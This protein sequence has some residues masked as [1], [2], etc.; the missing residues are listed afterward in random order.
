M[1]YPILGTP[2]PTF[3][4]SSGDPLVSGT[5]TVTDPDTASAKAVYD[6][7]ADADSQSNGVTSAITLNS[8]GEPETELWGRDGE[9]YTLVVKDSA[10]STVQTITDVR[11]P[12]GTTSSIRVKT[13]DE[14]LITATLAVDTHLTGWVVQPATYYSIEGYLLVTADAAS[15]DMD[16]KFQFTNAPQDSSYTYIAVDAT[17][18]KTV[19]EGAVQAA[20]ATVADIDIDGTADVG[21]IIRGFIFTH[22]TSSASI[23]FMAAQG[24]DAGTTTLKKGSW[25]K[26]EPLVV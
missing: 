2:I 25:I 21:I 9:D 10:G 11:L 8:R 13:A 5:V 12:L 22:A 16:M 4:D 7:A 14:S 26:I 15:R 18:A 23:D 17:T 3:L 19:D 6:S 24:T 1:A 20:T